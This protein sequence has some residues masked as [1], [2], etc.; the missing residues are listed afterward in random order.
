MRNLN[1][2]LA[3]SIFLAFSI[4]PAFAAA[5]PYGGIAVTPPAPNEVI[6]TVKN[7]SITKNYSMNDLLAKKSVTLKIFEPFVKKNQTFLAI[8]LSIFLAD[9]KISNKANLSTI[10]LNDYVYRNTASNFTKAKAY[11]AIRLSGKPIPYDQGG[12]IRIIYPSDSMWKKNL[13]PWNWSLRSIVV[14]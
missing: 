10:A 3:I 2:F 11:I 4:T 8:P 1:K 13:D 7:S 9:A 5:N 14:K 6:F 12:P